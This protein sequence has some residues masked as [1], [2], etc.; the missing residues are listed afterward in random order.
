MKVKRIGILV[1]T[2]V[3][4]STVALIGVAGGDKEG[5]GKPGKMEKVTI[6]VQMFSGPEFDAMVPTAEYWNENYAEETGITVNA[7]AGS[8]VGYFE[9]M[10]SQ[11][12]A[13][14]EEPDIVHPFNMF[15]G[16]LQPYLEPLDSY[17]EQEWVMSGPEGMDY[18][19]DMMLPVAL[20]TGRGLDGQIYMLPKDMSEVI[21]YYRTD[22]VP[23]P[24]DTYDEFVE[25]AKKNTQSLNPS[26]PTKYGAIVQGKY[27]LWTF[28]AGV[29]GL[30]PLGY[31]IFKPGTTEVAPLHPDTWKG[32]QF[33]QDLYEAGV[34]HPGVE[35]TEYPEVAA[36]LESGAVSMAIQWNANYFSATNCDNAPKVCDKIDIA[37]PPGYRQPDGSIDRSIY[38]QTICL[39]LNKASKKKE[40]AVKFLA[41]SCFGEG[42]K[43]YAEAGGSSPVKHV[44]LADDAM[45]PYPKLAP[46]VMEYGRPFPVYEHM[47]EIVMIGSS[48][49]QKV[50]IGRATAKEAAQGMQDEFASFV[51]S[52]M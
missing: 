25:I 48:W 37:P 31:E 5:G 38:V 20:E 40:P 21:L 34:L 7:I 26:S 13:G 11:L 2:I 28:C 46:M 45:M 24:P 18:S 47:S 50:L 30:W 29:E 43:L 15:I 3:F 23:N 9:K 22:V 41:W 42:A 19:V 10:Q 27:E 32:F 39:A 44:W 51:E 12:V 1:A 6:T 17:F 4:V 52:K 36:A 33:F 8:R 49:I 35:N 16:K 14:L